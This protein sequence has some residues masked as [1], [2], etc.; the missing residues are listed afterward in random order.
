MAGRQGL[1]E[2]LMAEGW[3]VQRVSEATQMLVWP[4]QFAAGGGKPMLL[5]PGLFSDHTF[6]LGTKGR[7]FVRYVREQN[8]KEPDPRR[9]HIIG[10]LDPRGVGLSSELVSSSK[11]HTFSHHVQIDIPK[12]VKILSEE[13][14]KG[15]KVALIGHSAGGAAVLAAYAQQ[16]ISIEHPSTIRKLTRALILL[17]TPAPF[18][19]YDLHKRIFCELACLLL[20]TLGRCPSRL[21]RLGTS[22]DLGSMIS[23]WL[24]WNTRRK[25]MALDGS[26]IL[27][28]VSEV[29]CPV[30]H[31]TGIGDT[32]AAP[33]SHCRALFQL[34]GSPDKTFI[35]F[36]RATGYPIDY[37]HANILAGG[38]SILVWN[39]LLT[40]LNERR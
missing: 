6:W 27:Q 20:L 16:G 2:M 32:F 5:V 28:K 18:G 34:I 35:E 33:P 22:D 23:S 11:E 9:K 29:S 36:G 4:S 26:D 21:L 3:K 40:W 17:S 31:G 13:Y 14:G 24:R 38:H 1:L 8:D 19:R 37:T 12:A 7:G 39:T 30:L 10:I 15:E 25:W